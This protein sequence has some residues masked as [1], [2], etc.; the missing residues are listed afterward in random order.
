MSYL[1]ILLIVVAIAGLIGIY[2]IVRTHEKYKQKY[3][4]VVKAE[5]HAFFE[6]GK[7]ANIDF[8]VIP[9]IEDLLEEKI[10]LTKV[11]KHED[12]KT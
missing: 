11:I 9:A 5:L 6:K 8:I 7:L 3:E 4:M 2:C 10:F 12:D 1:D